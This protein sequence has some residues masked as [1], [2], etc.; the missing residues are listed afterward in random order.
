M[1]LTVFVSEKCPRCYKP[2]MQSE[3]ARHPT[4]TDLALQNFTCAECGP[5]KTKSISLKPR[6]RPSEAAA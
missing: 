3:I 5:V 6:A 2:L 4:R 1:S